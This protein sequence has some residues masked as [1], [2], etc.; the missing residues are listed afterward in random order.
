M[1]TDQKTFFQENAGESYPGLSYDKAPIGTTHKGTIFGVPQPVTF[2]QGTPNERTSLAVNMDVDGEK[3]TLWVKSGSMARAVIKAC[4][5]AG[6]DGLA[7]GGVLAVQYVGEGQQSKPGF[8]PPK[9]Y[10][11]EYRP[12]A[13]PTVSVKGLLDQD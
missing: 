12:P 10:E 6:V 5:A 7:E 8:N 13:P 3:R 2:D 9:F 1:A 11:A 4:E